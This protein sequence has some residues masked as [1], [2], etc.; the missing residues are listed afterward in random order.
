MAAMV[1]SRRLVL[2]SGL[3]LH[4][5]E[6]GTDDPALDHTVLLLHG[7]LENAWAWEETVAA[8]LLGRFHLVA[9]DFRGHGDS[10]RVGPGGNYGFSDHLA[11]LHELIPLVARQR[12][13]IVGHSMGGAV[14]GLYAGVQPD[15]ISRLAILEGTGLPKPAWAGPARVARWLQ[16]RERV[17]ERPQRN[18]ATLEEAAARLR[19]RERVRERPQ[20]SYATLE[21]A[22]ERL[23]QNDPLLRKELALRL[24]EKGTVRGT[25]GRLRFK[26]DPRLAAGR[27]C[28]FDVEMARRF[29][30]EVRCPIL[31]VEGDRSELRLPT[32]EAQRR[33]SAFPKWKS[34]LLPEA[35]HMMQRHQPEALARILLEFLTEAP[36]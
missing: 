1:R 24:A 16:E 8:G 33:W 29:W 32:E 4:G 31:I 30:A 34:V 2:P 3:T 21:E 10:D 20:R 28:G 19:E 26:H 5:L 9:A 35:G 25:D 36:G 6:W 18:Y 11:D 27:P 7:F 17:R 22:A 13:S 23:R 12:L 15:R 14:G